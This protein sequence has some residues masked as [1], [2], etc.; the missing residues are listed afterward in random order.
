MRGTNSTGDFLSVILFLVNTGPLLV[1]LSKDFLL[2]TPFPPPTVFPIGAILYA[3]RDEGVE[4]K[5]VLMHVTGWHFSSGR[6][7]PDFSK[8]C[9]KITVQCELKLGS[10]ITFA[11]GKGTAMDTVPVAATNSSSDH[12]LSVEGISQKKKSNHKN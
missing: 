6:I 5:L 3:P 1:N 10:S 2:P 12:I 8:L 9:K 4:C 7:S 11:F